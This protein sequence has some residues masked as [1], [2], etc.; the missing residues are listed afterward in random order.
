MN[1]QKKAAMYIIGIISVIVILVFSTLLV[2]S[3]IN[4]KRRQELYIQPLM[5]TIEHCID[6]S[7]NSFDE[8]NASDDDKAYLETYITNIDK[9]DT[10]LE[11]AYMAQTMM[12]YVYEYIN[13]TNASIKQE[14]IND[15]NTSI[16]QSYDYVLSTVITA[17][18]E[19]KT[20]RSNISIKDENDK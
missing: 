17:N 13:I 16:I 3:A 9:V 19:L 12:T 11:K 10:P 8:I 18:N 20:A 6:V 1:K 7:R 2:I 4:E 5:E 15:P 14:A